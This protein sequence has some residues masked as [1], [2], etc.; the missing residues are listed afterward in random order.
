M[1]I[2][3]PFIT[4][5]LIEGPPCNDLVFWESNFAQQAH[6]MNRSG[7]IIIVHQPGLP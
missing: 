1:G 3:T 4:N 7:Q 5:R 2:V 6:Q